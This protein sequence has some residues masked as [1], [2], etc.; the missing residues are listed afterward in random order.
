M[1]GKSPRTDLAVERLEIA[2]QVLPQGVER[3]EAE[4]E[5]VKITSVRI[6]EAEAARILGKPEG[7][8]ITLEVDKLGTNSTNFEGEVTVVAEQ[9][10]PLLP[11][12]G[13][14]LVVGLGNSDITPDAIGPLAADTV[15]ATRHITGEIAEM[16]G[17]PGL[18]PVAVLAPGVLGQTGMETAEIIASVC[19]GIEPSAVIVV[20][21]L[22]SKSVSRLGRTVQISD[23]GISP[24]SGVQNRRKELSQATLGVPVLSVGVPTVVDLQTICH[25]LTAGK[26]AGQVPDEA[27]GM[28]VT[29]REIDTLVEGAARTVAFAINHA[30]QPSLSFEELTGLVS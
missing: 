2:G 4:K 25:D 9:L 11:S 19:R 21:A 7:T 13:T 5:G 24:G 3:Q 29:P 15:L 18:R 27:E 20:D 26:T 6:G 10:K 30:L 8:Y 22:A 14:V 17:L 16:A 23:T 28:M 1:D 12:E